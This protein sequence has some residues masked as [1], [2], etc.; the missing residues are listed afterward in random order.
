MTRAVNALFIADSIGQALQNGSAFTNQ[1]D[2]SNGC[3]SNGTCY[4]LIQGPPVLS[5]AAILL[6]P[7]LGTIRQSNADACLQPECLV[8]VKRICGPGE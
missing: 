5:C 4:D 3:A 7:A 2:L 6:V 1:W 8:A